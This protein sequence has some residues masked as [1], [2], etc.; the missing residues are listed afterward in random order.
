MTL[1]L[2][3]AFEKGFCMTFLNSLKLFGSNWVK[4]LKFILFYF[5]VWGI[6]FALALPA[7][8]EF[9]DLIFSVFNPANA[10][11]VVNG[12]F[13]GSI[14]QNLFVLFNNIAVLLTMMF[15]QKLSM[16]I[17]GLVVIFV[18]LPF[19]INVGKYAFNEMMYSYMTSKNKLG[20][21]SA[22]I[23]TLKK[24]LVFAL[25]KMLLNLLFSAVA[26]FSLYGLA[27]IADPIFVTYFLPLVAF[28]VLVILYTLNQ[29][30]ILGW[31]PAMIVFDCNVFSAF[32]KGYKA[33]K[34]HFWSTFATT[35]L[36]F[37]IFWAIM[38]VCGLL[39][40]VVLLPLMTALLCIFDMVVFFTSQGM[41][42]Y[43]NEN[44]ILTPKKL[45]EVDNI[46]KSATIL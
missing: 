43:I 15:A 17:Y 31:A 34:R 37:S 10:M 33:V 2:Y 24:S 30:T 20:F 6:C 13:G 39:S 4:V 35:A 3:L 21:F 11:S 22:L 45:E 12:V 28:V 5:V 44:K 26:I 19:F 9:K 16:A 14:G 29:L 27:L 41:R 25:C 32:K 18:F 38:I 8:F 1:R 42:F 23:K 7:Y 40:F 36:Y 46:H